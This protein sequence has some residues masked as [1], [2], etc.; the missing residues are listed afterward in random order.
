MAGLRTRRVLMR[1]AW[2]WLRSLVVLHCCRIRVL[3]FSGNWEMVVMAVRG[4]AGETVSVEAI[5]CWSR[6]PKA[7]RLL[8][9]QLILNTQTQ[10]PNFL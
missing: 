5:L 6:T 1:W 7:E 3:G 9:P 8:L 4:L 2:I 10:P